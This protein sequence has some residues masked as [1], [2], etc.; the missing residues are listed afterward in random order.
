MSF[1]KIFQLIF[2]FPFTVLYGLAIAIR[3]QLYRWGLLRSVQFDVPII[4]VGNLSTGGTGKTPHVE[5][6]IRLL[7]PYINVAT[8][9]RGYKRKTKG[10]ISVPPNANAL[11]VGDEPLQFKRKY[12]D[13]YVTVA[14]SRSVAVTNIMM[15]APDTQVILMDDGFQHR[16]LKAGHQVLLTSYQELFTR[17]YLLPGGNLREWR[18]GYKRADTIV[19]TKCPSH[20]NDES[21]EEIIA[22]IKPLP[23]QEVFFSYYRYGFPYYFFDANQQLELTEELSVILICGLASSDYLVQHLD[24]T[25][26]FARILEFADH[27]LFKPRDLETLKK[28]FAELPAK[29]KIILTTEKDAI[30]LELHRQFLIDHQLPVFILPIEVI[31]HFGEAPAFDNRIKQFLLDFKT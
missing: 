8:L 16:S 12:R 17:D 25:V 21:R 23:H 29:Q 9:S 3:N 20:F 28:Q 6:L 4:I 31:F 11:V 2:S 1:Q 27:Y 18:A 5:Y 14:E 26:G 13:A 19:V 7:R 10:F 30:R 22:E 24:N 15:N